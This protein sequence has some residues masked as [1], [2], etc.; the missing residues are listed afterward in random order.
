MRECSTEQYDLGTFSYNFHNPSPSLAADPM[1]VEHYYTH[2]LSLVK[3]LLDC[4]VEPAVYEDKLREMFGVNSYVAFT[5]DK[6][7]SNIVRQVSLLL[8]LLLLFLFIAAIFGYCSFLAHFVNR[9][10]CQNSVLSMNVIYD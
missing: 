10:F 5:L 1:P 6:L 2:F 7:I 8:S 3:D 9:S 4:N